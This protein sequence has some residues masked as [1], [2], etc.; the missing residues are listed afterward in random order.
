MSL[1][2]FSILR[3]ELVVCLLIF[4]LLVMKL[5]DADKH[6]KSFLITVNT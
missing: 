5:A 3:F 2:L 1:E 6:L 4:I